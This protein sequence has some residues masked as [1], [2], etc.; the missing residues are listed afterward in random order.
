MQ[1]FQ[2]IIWNTLTRPEV[3]NGLIAAK[4]KRHLKYRGHVHFEPVSPYV[5]HPTLTQNKF[6]EDSFITTD[7]SN[8]EMF[9]FAA[10][11]QIQGETGSVTYKIILNWK[12]NKWKYK[13][14]WYRIC[15]SWRSPNHPQNCIRQLLFLIVPAKR[16]IGFNFKWWIL[17]G[18]RTSW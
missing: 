1:R 11:G 12:W 16:K 13:W 6:Y 8:E 5:I 2:K 7:P 10:I 14:D 18:S 15:S 4:L 9:R 3:S 17:W